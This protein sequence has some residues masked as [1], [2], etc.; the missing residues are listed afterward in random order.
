V[1]VGVNASTWVAAADGF[2]IITR[3]G[4]NTVQENNRTN[5]GISQKRVFMVPSD[6]FKLCAP[7]S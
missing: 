6:E 4:A 7:N 1:G 3:A 5:R 2:V